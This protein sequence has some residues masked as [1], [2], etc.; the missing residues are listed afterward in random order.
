MKLPGRGGG[1]LL[2][3]QGLWRLWRL[4]VQ[5]EQL[6][7]YW[8]ARD[9]TLDPTV[10]WRA[11]ESAAISI[12]PGTSIGAYTLIDLWPD[13]LAPQAPPGG[14]RI[15]ARVAINEF[16]NLRAAGGWIEIGNGCL[17]SQF[18]TLVGSNHGLVADR[19]MR[20]QP[21]SRQRLGVHLGADILPKVIN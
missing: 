2:G 6:R 15:G 5:S 16:N 10:I 13:P 7:R 12:G 20:D 9:V 19:W 1:W 21:W 4:H 3:A 8:Q 17:I 14:L 11:P 18:V